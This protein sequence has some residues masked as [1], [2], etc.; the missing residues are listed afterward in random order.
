MNV[1]IKNLKN[2]AVPLSNPELTSGGKDVADIQQGSDLNSL[3]KM[4]A[5]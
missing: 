5:D 4:Q 2:Q 1:R 3:A